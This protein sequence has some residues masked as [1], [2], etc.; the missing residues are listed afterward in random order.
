MWQKLSA[1]KLFLKKR[2]Q[3]FIYV[4]NC[5]NVWKLREISQKEKKNKNFKR[6]SFDKNPEMKH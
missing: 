1:A 5:F 4:S 6:V 3:K 2:P